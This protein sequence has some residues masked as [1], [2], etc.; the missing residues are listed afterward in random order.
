MARALQT[1]ARVS[2]TDGAKEDMKTKGTWARVWGLRSG[3]LR[4]MSVCVGVLVCA[5]VCMSVHQEGVVCGSEREN[6]SQT[7]PWKGVRALFQT[8]DRRQRDPSGL[9]TLDFPSLFCLRL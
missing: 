7:Q 6:F 8:N 2:N 4:V 5:C 1:R 9:F 3:T